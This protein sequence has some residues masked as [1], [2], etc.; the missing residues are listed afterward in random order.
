M[1]YLKVD[2]DSFV[3]GLE[4]SVYKVILCY[5]DWG[6]LLALLITKHIYPH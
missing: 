5:G 3:Q 4:A 6:E 1:F 2:A